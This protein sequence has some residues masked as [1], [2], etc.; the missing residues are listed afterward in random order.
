MI[1]TLLRSTELLCTWENIFSH[2]DPEWKLILQIDNLFCVSCENVQV[3]VWY[4]SVQCVHPNWAPFPYTLF[5]DLLSSKEIILYEAVSTFSFL[6]SGFSCSRLRLKG[7]QSNTAHENA[8]KRRSFWL[9]III[10]IPLFLLWLFH[11]LAQPPLYTLNFFLGFWFVGILSLGHPCFFPP[12]IIL[13]ISLLL[14]ATIRPQYP[15]CFI[16]P[17]CRSYY[18]RFRNSV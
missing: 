17:L 11:F 12:L 9:A 14:F 16:M 10:E 18:S 8:T 6:L 15:L 5:Q 13:F 4:M 3:K 1:Y 2:H 7:L